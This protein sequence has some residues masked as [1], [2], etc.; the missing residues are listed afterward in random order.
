MYRTNQLIF[1]A[2]FFNSTVFVMKLKYMPFCYELI[3]PIQL[4]MTGFILSM[5][6]PACLVLYVKS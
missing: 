6:M 2:H 1:T 3:L 4:S 5:Q